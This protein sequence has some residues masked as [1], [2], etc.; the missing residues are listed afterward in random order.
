MLQVN[1]YPVRKLSNPIGNEE[2]Q[3]QELIKEINFACK[4][5]SSRKWNLAD[6]WYHMADFLDYLELSDTD[7]H[8]LTGAEKHRHKA[9]LW[10]QGVPEKGVKIIDPD[11]PNE[12]SYVNTGRRDVGI[13]KTIADCK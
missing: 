6:Y 9:K 13:I 10:I 12:C 1:E 8:G 2:N 3:F 4:K 7:E 11:Y 5:L